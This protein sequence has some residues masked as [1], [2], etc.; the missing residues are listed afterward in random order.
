MK[1]STEQIVQQYYEAWR[2]GDANKLLLAEDFTF[3]GPIA[4]FSNP[5]EFRAM[6]K[7]IS[8]MVKGVKLLEALY[9]NNQAFVLLEFATNMPELGSW[10]AIDYFLIEGE[11]IK[12]SRTSYDPRRLVEFMQSR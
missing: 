8:P 4:S 9:G 6:A 3:D 2:T 11:K 10:I 12:H 7:Q 5:E 1:L